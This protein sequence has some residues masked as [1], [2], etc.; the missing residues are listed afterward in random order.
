MKG[1]GRGEGQGKWKGRK[2]LKSVREEGILYDGKVLDGR[3]GTF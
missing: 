3:E 2:G 1:R